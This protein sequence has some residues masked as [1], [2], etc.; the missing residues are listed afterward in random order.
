MLSEI[1]EYDKHKFSNIKEWVREAV[2]LEKTHVKRSKWG[3][4]FGYAKSN[5]EISL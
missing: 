2:T 1:E 3:R 4:S 5:E